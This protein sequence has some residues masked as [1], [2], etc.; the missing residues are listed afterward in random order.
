MKSVSFV[1]SVCIC[2]LITTPILSVAQ[3][4][5]KLSG[6]QLFQ[7]HCASCHF[8]GGNKIKSGRD[9][10]GSKQLSS[11]P[12]FKAYL[13]SPPGHMPHYQHLVS[14]RELLKS[15]YDYCKTLKVVPVRQAMQTYTCN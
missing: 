6:Q 13:S 9:L 12:V 2:L 8:A 10:A 1:L 15:L 7:Q 5:N 14:D 4:K 11:L 3:A